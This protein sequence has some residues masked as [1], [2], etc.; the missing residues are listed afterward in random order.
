[1][2]AFHILLPL[3]PLNSCFIFVKTNDILKI[4]F[5]PK[6][7]IMLVFLWTYWIAPSHVKN[8]CNLAVVLGQAMLVRG[9]NTWAFN[10][11]SLIPSHYTLINI[12]C[13][14]RVTWL[15]KVPGRITALKWMLH[16]VRPFV[17]DSALARTIFKIKENPYENCGSSISTV[18][19]YLM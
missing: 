7:C 16:E 18:L 3:S 17:E 8:W 5:C 12:A 4:D 10:K 1:M 19:E 11:S 13:T 9:V 15:L 6:N 14:S 2:F